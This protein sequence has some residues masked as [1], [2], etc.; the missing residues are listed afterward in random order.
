MQNKICEQCGKGFQG[1][2]WQLICVKCYQENERN[3]V[4]TQRRRVK[5]FNRLKVK[6]IPLEE[7]K[8]RWDAMRRQ[9]KRSDRRK[10]KSSKAQSQLRARIEVEDF[11][12]RNMESLT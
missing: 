1:E 10:S 6:G 2:D 7:V 3:N 12:E 11:K 5:F 8:E 4:P 9:E